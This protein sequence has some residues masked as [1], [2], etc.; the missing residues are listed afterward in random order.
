[1]NST[2][3]LLL[4]FALI[5]LATLSW[6]LSQRSLATRASPGNAGACLDI[7]GDRERDLLAVDVR[8]SAERLALE[9]PTTNPRLEERGTKFRLRLPQGVVETPILVVTPAGADPLRTAWSADLDA[10][11]D[12]SSWGSAKV[13]LDGEFVHL[14]QPVQLRAP[15][16][17][18]VELDAAE[19]GALYVDVLDAPWSGFP[20]RVTAVRQGLEAPIDAMVAGHYRNVTA[21]GTIE[22]RGLLPGRYELFLE[23]AQAAIGETPPETVRTRVDIAARAFAYATL[24]GIEPGIARLSGRVRCGDRPVANATIFVSAE[25]SAV[26][27]GYSRTSTRDDGTFLVEVA[28][29]GDLE[30]LVRDVPD[31]APFQRRIEVEERGARELDLDLAECA[32]EG[33][34]LDEFGA[35]AT[36]V[37]VTLVPASAGSV[38]AS[39]WAFARTNADGRYRIEGLTR[40]AYALSIGGPAVG[41]ALPGQ[42]VRTLAT[43]SV[44]CAAAR[45]VVP[46]IH[47]ASAATLHGRMRGASGR[48]LDGTTIYVRPVDGAESA[49]TAAALVRNDGSFDARFLEPVPHFV[50]AVLSSA[51]EPPLAS[52]IARA[53]P[54]GGT[55]ELELAPAGQLVLSAEDPTRH[56]HPFTLEVRDAT[57]VLYPLFGRHRELR[58]EQETE[59]LPVGTYSV[60]VTLA[61]GRRAQRVALVPEARRGRCFVAVD[62]R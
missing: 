24:P 31:V 48:V 45:T 25:R 16:P 8:P 39:P 51:N 32:V 36:D 59:P 30:V 9:S 10:H 14:E 19:T 42:N 53:T 2:R 12:L 33:I 62:A 54:G 3:R 35:P 1:M 61:D 18:V 43:R 5:G 27:G 58:W 7:V 57:G 55:C 52:S 6:K 49:W 34:V 22:M 20:A 46:T 28:G 29:H 38:G 23:P 26:P 37:R 17:A 47:L 21:T 13:D 41:T 56:A 4:A 15:Y 44:D 60:D 11:V 50:Y 40:G